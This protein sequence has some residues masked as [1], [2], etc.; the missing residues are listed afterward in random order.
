MEL[1]Y[2]HV[3]DSHSFPLAAREGQKRVPWPKMAQKP[4][5]VC[6]SVAQQEKRTLN[7]VP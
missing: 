6:G 1:A 3:L 2:I 7:Y 5:L 4:T